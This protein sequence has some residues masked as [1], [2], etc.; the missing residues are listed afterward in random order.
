[1]CVLLQIQSGADAHV[2]AYAYT[3]T[4]TSESVCKCVCVIQTAA[5][6]FEP[7]KISRNINFVLAAIP[8]DSRHIVRKLI[9]H[10]ATMSVVVV[11]L[12]LP[13]SFISIHFPIH[14]L[15]HRRDAAV[16]ITIR[17]RRFIVEILSITFF[18]D[19]Y[20]MQSSS[21]T[22]PFF[23]NSTFIDCNWCPPPVTQPYRYDIRLHL[24]SENLDPMLWMCV[25]VAELAR[26]FQPAKQKQKQ[27][28]F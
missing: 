13:L 12:S 11:S 9:Y 21:M 26:N 8:I 28:A 7:N 15:S 1:M 17:F 14:S 16:C 19:K 18:I 23:F 3:T 4:R 10:R 27:I 25:L 5:E 22:S 2:C 24:T 6:I 20:D